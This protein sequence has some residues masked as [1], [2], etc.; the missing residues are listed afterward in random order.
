M[1]Y[2]G[3]NLTAEQLSTVT[4]F[5]AA[6]KEGRHLTWALVVCGPPNSGKTTLVQRITDYVGANQT[7][8]FD[9]CSTIP[10]IPSTTTV[11]FTSEL[12]NQDDH[13]ELRRNAARVRVTIKNILEGAFADLPRHHLQYLQYTQNVVLVS[14]QPLP[15]NIPHRIVTL[16][17][18]MQ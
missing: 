4:E 7:S 15:F 14:E 6:C 16:D 10:P 8:R 9:L 17:R 1:D 3:F 12:D 2:S 13:D 11:L 5:V 18:R